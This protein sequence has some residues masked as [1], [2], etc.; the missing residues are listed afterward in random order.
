MLEI[1]RKTFC[2]V[3]KR[4]NLYTAKNY[5]RSQGQ[6]FELNLKLAGIILE[7]CKFEIIRLKV[8]TLSR[9]QTFLMSKQLLRNLAS[10]RNDISTQQQVNKLSSLGSSSLDDKLN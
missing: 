9:L 10:D 7:P 5:R 6:H 1:N 8:P 2:A 4:L 3:H